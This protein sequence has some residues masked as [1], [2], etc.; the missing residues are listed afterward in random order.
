MPY[1]EN[2]FLPAVDIAVLY[3]MVANNSP[4]KYIEVGSGT[5]TKVAAQA[6]REYSPLTQIYS[7]DPQPRSKI[8]SVVDFLISKPFE[9]IDFFKEVNI[10][11]GDI[12]FID[13]SHR[14]LPNSDVTVL[15]LEI[16]PKLPQGVIV[17]FHD[18]Y[19]PYDYP[20][21]MCD[22]FYSEQYLLAAFLL[23][24]PSRYHTICPNYF[25]SEDP[26]LSEII[27]H[28]WD[29]ESLSKAERHGGSYWIEIR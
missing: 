3:A 12:L 20:Q 18:I 19:L 11:A 14:V 5:S 4:S 8:S 15:F 25:I 29:I 26:E 9:E 7:I 10:E 23:N 21:F 27:S 2:D 17:H 28:L 24:N 22:R 13:N 6:I 1:W 16:L